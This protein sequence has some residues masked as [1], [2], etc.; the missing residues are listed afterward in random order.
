MNSLLRHGV[1]QRAPQVNPHAKPTEEV[2]RST[3]K[4]RHNS[5]HTI[6]NII[7]QSLPEYSEEFNDVRNKKRTLNVKIPIKELWIETSENEASS[8]VSDMELSPVCTQY[9]PSIYVTPKRENHTPVLM[10][11]NNQS[12]N[13]TCSEE[14]VSN[15][16]EI[17]F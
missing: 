2:R 16:D 12:R 15:E 9:A 4:R 17:S 10:V 7:T 8:N 3:R 5:N 1:N 11:V 6:E 14:K 13:E